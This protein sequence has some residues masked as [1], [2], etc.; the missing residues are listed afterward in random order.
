MDNQSIRECKEF[1]EAND[2]KGLQEH[3]R[4]LLDYEYP[5]T[6]DMAYI[7]HR[8]YLHAC[9]KGNTEAEDWLRRC[10]FPTLDG[11]QQIALKQIFPYGRHLLVKARK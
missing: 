7:F 9:L 2:I 11:I 1:V 3:Y 8:V 4:K 10:V 5:Q 6:P